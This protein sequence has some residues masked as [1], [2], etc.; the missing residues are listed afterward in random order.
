MRRK[1]MNYS[2][3]SEHI[4]LSMSMEQN[5]NQFTKSEQKIF[6]YVMKHFEELLYKSLTEIANACQVGEATVLRFCRKLGFKG[7]QDFKLSLARELST[8]QKSDTTETYVSKI[9]NNMVQAVEYTYALVD[10]L[11]LKEAINLLDKSRNIVVYGVSSSGIAGMDMQNRL[12]RIG[13]NIEVITDSHNQMI[14]SNSLSED[15]VIVAI[16]LT[17]S[18]KDIV[19]AVENGKKQGA[20]VIAITNYMESPL[21]SFADN[22]LLTSAK[23]NPLD[24]GSLVSKISQ[25]YIIDLLCTGITMNNHASAKRT[26]ELIAETV[27]DKLY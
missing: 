15:A 5:K 9:R 26:K 25:L 10:E 4:S 11:Q 20:R 2:L 8:Q 16:S 21:A 24:S 6:T 3:H 17:G 19:D 27:S 13:R 14:R 23:E 1:R 12:M 22:I 18:T 7:Y